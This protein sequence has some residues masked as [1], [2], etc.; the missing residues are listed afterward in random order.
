VVWTDFHN[1]YFFIE[2]ILL[3]LGRGT[4]LVL[5]NF[6]ITTPGN[7]VRF[8]T[9]KLRLLHVGLALPSVL[10]TQ[11]FSFPVWVPVVVSLVV[12]VVLVEGVVQVTVNPGELRDVSEEEGHL[13]V[14]SVLVVVPG[15]NGINLLVEVGVNNLI[16]PVVVRLPLVPKVTRV[17]RGVKVLHRHF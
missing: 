1:A 3:A 12:S 14:L 10:N 17:V 11:S 6:S 7:K 2:T 13:R 5:P 4:G 16:S 15:S 8:E 9:H